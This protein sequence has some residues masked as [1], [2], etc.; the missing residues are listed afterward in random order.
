[1][2]NQATTNPSVA[3]RLRDATLKQAK[4]DAQ[5]VVGKIIKSKKLFAAIVQATRDDDLWLDALLDDLRLHSVPAADRTILKQKV[6]QR[7]KDEDQAAGGAGPNLWTVDPNA[8]PP[9]LRDATNPAAPVSPDAVVPA[10]YQVTLDG[11]Y[12]TG[13]L[14]GKPV[15]VQVAPRPIVVSGV[16][17][18]H[19][20]SREQ[21]RLG[22]W[23]G[24]RWRHH[25]VDRGVALN[26]TRLALEADY[27]LPV[28][29][30]TAGPVVR[31]LMA[32]EEA[33]GIVTPRLWTT[34]HLGWQLDRKPA[35]FLAGHRALVVG[36]PANSTRVVDT[37]PPDQWH[38]GALAFRA[39]SDGDEQLAR[40]FA[41]RGTF[42]AWQDAVAPLAAY[43][44]AVLALFASLTAPLLEI[45]GA[46]SFIV[47]WCGATS[48]GKTTTIMGGASVWGNPDPHAPASVTGTFNATKVSIERRA[49]L[50]KGLPVILDDTSMGNPRDIPT[51][52]YMLAGG[53]G[54]GRGQRTDGVRSTG[55]WRTVGLTTGEAPLTAFSEAGGT[56][57][58][59]ITEWG[60][61]FGTPSPETGK[62][63]AQVGTAIREAY[64]HAGP[65]FV[66]HLLDERAAW[67]AWRKNYRDQRAAYIAANDGTPVANRLA[68]HA[69]AIRV[70]ADLAHDIGL[71]PWDRR[72]PVAPL[73]AE[74]VA[75][76]S[77]ADRAAEALRRVHAWTVA[78][79]EH[80]DGQ[81]REVGLSGA[82][83][84]PAAGALGV[85]D[86]KDLRI[87][88]VPDRLRAFL[89]GEGFSPDAILRTW[90]ERGWLQLGK[91]HNATTTTMAVRL[92]GTSTRMVVVRMA[93]FVEV[94]IG[95]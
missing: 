32:Y 26:R 74:I 1:M 82:K 54:R 3:D 24:K 71:L 88:Y 49:A 4:S 58:R 8:P 65:R 84:A 6:K 37:T 51:I 44:R 17:V 50:F 95:P 62:V 81:F 87:A 11:V 20:T 48:Q 70:A 73:W 47:D 22:W 63:V 34:G 39:L 61:P 91:D 66:Q 92:L 36:V 45:L 2:G 25:I 31:Y 80:F 56:R 90:R 33:N 57:G 5:G 41:A 55:S 21:W 76:A 75:G 9:L 30:E 78:H 46:A 67:D 13:K 94:G 85:W 14:G 7:I 43:D 12:T 83:V 60:S 64:G 29:S 79:K 93:A 68:E 18:D 15:R 59:V 35:A 40:A 10:G 52:V 53:Q 23:D 77:E 69:A 72:D 42:Q 19:Q 28:S 89:E 16:L 86:D 27:G 38:A